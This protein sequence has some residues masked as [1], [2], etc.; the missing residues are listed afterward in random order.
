MTAVAMFRL[1]EGAGGLGL[2][3]DGYGLDLAGVP[4]LRRECGRLRPRSAD[5]ITKLLT[6]AYGAA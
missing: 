1:S 5:E 3:G 4:L 6:S 2:S